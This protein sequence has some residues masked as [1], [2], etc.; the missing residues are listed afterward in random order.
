MTEPYI[1]WEDDDSKAAAFEKTKDNV[2]SYGAVKANASHRSF[3][4]IETNRSVKTGYNREDYDRFRSSERT[5]TPF[6]CV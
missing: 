3:L 4:D 5:K 2:E 1:T 6:V